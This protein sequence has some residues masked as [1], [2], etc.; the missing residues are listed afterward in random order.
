MNIVTADR[1]GRDGRFGSKIEKRE[2]FSFLLDLAVLI[3]HHIGHGIEL[4]KFYTKHGFSLGF[5]IY[6]ITIN[7]GKI[8]H[9]YTY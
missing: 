2:T 3:A 7:S 9:L 5:V 1:D 8:Q 4:N 6:K